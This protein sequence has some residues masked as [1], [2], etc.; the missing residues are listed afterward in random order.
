MNDQ[1]QTLPLV[2]LEVARRIHQKCEQ[3]EDAWSGS[4]DV[5]IDG[6]GDGLSDEDEVLLGTDPT[7]AD[8][9]GDHVVD[10]TYR[11]PGTDGFGQFDIAQAPRG[12]AVSFLGEALTPLS[13]P[14]PFFAY[15]FLAATRC[16][17]AWAHYRTEH[18]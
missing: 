2:P 6:D 8:S 11:C 10:L 18:S 1:A 7:N 15:P 13:Q 5:L 14:L 3:F 16:G 4:V 12:V 9:D 17:W